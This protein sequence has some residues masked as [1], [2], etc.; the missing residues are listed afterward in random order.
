MFQNARS[1]VD[2]IPD[3]R[4]SGPAA[5]LD[6]VGSPPPAQNNLIA[7]NHYGLSIR[8]SRWFVNIRCTALCSIVTRLIFG[9]RYA[10]RACADENWIDR[11]PRF[12][13]A[14]RGIRRWFGVWAL[15]TGVAD[16]PVTI[17]PLRY[18]SCCNDAASGICQ[19]SDVVQTAP[20]SHQPKSF[21]LGHLKQ[22]HI[23]VFFV[24]Q[25]PYAQTNMESA[26]RER[27]DG[28]LAAGTQVPLI[29][30]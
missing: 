21:A 29:V 12:A 18:C 7:V 4:S 24:T 26:L 3:T 5:F 25:A 19:A 11:P 22:I 13:Y 1:F 23:I 17:G 9:S 14:R 15:F 6:V 2:I 16:P 10:A 20:A 28:L 27:R 30:A 8:I